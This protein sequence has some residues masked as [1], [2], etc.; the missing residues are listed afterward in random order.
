MSFTVRNSLK[1]VIAAMQ[2]L[3]I[4]VFSS[5]LHE[6]QKITIIYLQARFYDEKQK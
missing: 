4:Y 3:C 6:K 1:K 2:I 5:L